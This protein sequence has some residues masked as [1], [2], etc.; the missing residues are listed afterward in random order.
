MSVGTQTPGEPD[1]PVAVVGAVRTVEKQECSYALPLVK[2]AAIAPAEPA[3][4][5]TAQSSNAMSTTRPQVV[6]GF[7][8]CDDT[9]KSCTVEKKNASPSVLTSVPFACRSAK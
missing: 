5:T 3:T 1:L 8:I 7:L 4:T 2:K 6:S 9:V